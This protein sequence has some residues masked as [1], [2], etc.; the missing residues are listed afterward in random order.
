MTLEPAEI[1]QRLQE[2]EQDLGHRQN[3]YAS[4]AERSSLVCRKREHQHAVEFMKATGGTVTER[5]EQAREQ[6]SLIGMEE[7]A[8]HE[9]LKAAIK[10]MDTRSMILMALLKSAGRT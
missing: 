4:A 5:K 1:E 10:V 3:A 8:E 9:G 2:L 7:E 6:T